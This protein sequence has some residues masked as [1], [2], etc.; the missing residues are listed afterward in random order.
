MADTGMSS[1]GATSSSSSSGSSSTPSASP[2]SPS[3][4]SQNT[5]AK[6]QGTQ[7]PTG[8]APAKPA[9]SGQSFTPDSGGEPQQ[10]DPQAAEMAELY[11][12]KVKVK[13]DGQ[14]MEL[15][16]EELMKGYST[17]QGAMKR[18]EEAAKIRKQAEGFVEQLLTDPKAV[19]SHPKFAE[20]GFN[21]RQF[22]ESILKEEIEREMLSPEEL[23]QREKDR[24]LEELRAERDKGKKTQEQQQY[25]NHK[26]AAEA[27]FSTK[28]QEAL[29]TAKLPKSPFTLKRMAEYQRQ[30]LRAGYELSAGEL[31]DLV[32]EEFQK[33]VTETFGHLDAEQIIAV[34]G[35]DTAKKIRE[36]DLKRVQQPAMQQQQSNQY[37]VKKPAARSEKMTVAAW[38]EKLRKQYR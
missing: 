30:A 21:L 38:Q 5:Q 4:P 16:I 29:E 15:P 28:F 3:S 19:L 20:K 24:E 10:A 17:R 32:R 34:F 8:N 25:E 23:Q 35:E 26:K 2:T 7:I 27:K 6:S 1:G 33:E 9:A 18:F 22:A 37:Q 36:Y 11:K 31:G 14:D 12:K 13:V